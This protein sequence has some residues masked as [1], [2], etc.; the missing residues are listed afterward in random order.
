[1]ESFT[2]E[3]QNVCA[4][5]ISFDMNEGKLYNVKFFGGCPGN[6]TAIAKLV[7]GADAQKIR[8]I[9]KGNICGARGTSCADQ[10]ALAIESALEKENVL[11]K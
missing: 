2:F 5:A 7:E 1:M 4:R 11:N 3:T 9:L 10:L 6:T 8:E